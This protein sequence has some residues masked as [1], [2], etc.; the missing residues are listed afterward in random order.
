MVSNPS[1]GYSGSDYAALYFDSLIDNKTDVLIW[2]FAINDF[3][4]GRGVGV[5]THGGWQLGW[6]RY[7]MQVVELFLRR[8]AAALPKA[9]LVFLFLWPPGGR[10]CWPSCRKG[11]AATHW[12]EVLSVLKHYEKSVDA[13]AIHFER[14]SSRL[15]LGD[16]NASSVDAATIE[17]A[18][19]R[20]FSD[21]HHMT[22][23]GHM[24][25]GSTIAQLL[26]PRIAPSA[27]K[28]VNTLP[29]S[30][31][32]LPELA[33]TSFGRRL[34]LHSCSIL[35]LQPSLTVTAKEGVEM[36]VGA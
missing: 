6:R 24:A 11:P 2:E 7:H 17:A 22:T 15:F 13:T 14:I 16:N 5:N 21:D 4:P 28:V 10:H 29:A 34:V 27:H 12:Q 20:L 19:N 3:T 26:L 36:A 33:T 31:F 25:A 23:E 18:R 35:Y 1:Q 8:A 32:A 9:M 30:A